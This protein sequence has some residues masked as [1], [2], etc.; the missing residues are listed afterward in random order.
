MVG[1]GAMT[2]SIQDTAKTMSA[3]LQ[4][5]S[6]KREAPSSDSKSRPSKRMR[7]SSPPSRSPSPPS[8]NGTTMIETST[9][10]VVEE[11]TRLNPSDKSLVL[12]IVLNNRKKSK[13]AVHFCY[14][15]DINV[16]GVETPQ[17]PGILTT[18]FPGDIGRV[19]PSLVNNYTK[20]SFDYPESHPARPFAWAQWICGIYNLSPGQQH[21]P[22]PS[23]RAVVNQMNNRFSAQIDLATQLKGLEKHSPSVQVHD[24][25]KELFDQEISTK[26]ES[27]TAIETPAKDIFSFTDENENDRYHCRYYTAI[28]KHDKARLQATVEISP[29]YPIRPPRFLFQPRTPGKETYETSLKD[30]EIEVNSFYD[31]LIP[32]QSQNWILSHQLRK[33]EQCFD[34]INTSGVQTAVFGRSR[35]GKDRRRA[36]AVPE[37]STEVTHR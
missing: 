19:N 12:E 31:E 13:L 16:V 2:L 33:V 30:I 26:L 18:L 36:L 5:F 8:Q 7:S 27:W 17:Y 28:F 9:A 35:R 14:F 22:E 3:M 15:P 4:P 25:A 34:I 1:D 6:R 20:E 37:G 24:N 10:M 32:N 11:T 23:I 29:E 21:R